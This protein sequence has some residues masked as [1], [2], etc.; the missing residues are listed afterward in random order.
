MS[1]TYAIYI[2][3][4]KNK[5]HIHHPLWLSQSRLFSGFF[6]FLFTLAEALM[7]GSN[8]SYI[9]SLQRNLSTSTNWPPIISSY[10]QTKHKN[11]FN[12]NIN[13]VF[14]TFLPVTKSPWNAPLL[15]NYVLKHR[16][17]MSALCE[18]TNGTDAPPI[19][20][21]A[22]PACT[23]TTVILCHEGRRLQ[24]KVKICCFHEHL[25]IF[26]KKK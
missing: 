2:S 26:W 19:L 16:I 10:S 24:T 20:E 7:E 21:T 15:R 1:K 13:N 22:L 12:A 9:I 11:L 6:F 18:V 3:V 23:Q 25:N 8:A 14:Y 17:R 5:Y 4:L